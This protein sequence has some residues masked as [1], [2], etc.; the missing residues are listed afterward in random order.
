MR[1]RLEK[2]LATVARD[3]A[4]L[5]TRLKDTAFL[6]RAPAEVVAADRIRRDELSAKRT[7]LERYLVGLGAR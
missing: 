7:A 5:D 2:Q 4:G 3:L 1:T 6:D